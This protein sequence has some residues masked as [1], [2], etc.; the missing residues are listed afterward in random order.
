MHR[1]ILVQCVYYDLDAFN[2][3]G[4]RAIRAATIVKESS[5]IFSK[6]TKRVVGTQQRQYYYFYQ[7][8]TPKLE[9]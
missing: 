7:N 8:L 9:S 5:P 4:R 2:V 1:S 6:K 3:C